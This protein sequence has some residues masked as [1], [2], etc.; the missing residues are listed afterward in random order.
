MPIHVDARN[1][2]PAKELHGAGEG[3]RTL[4]IQ[5]GKLTLYQL[6]YARSGRLG[7]AWGGK[8]TRRE[9]EVK[10]RPDCSEP[11]GRVGFQKGVLET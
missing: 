6:S 9:G 3:T 10:R 11:A 5:L 7:A 4:D 2:A 1:S 8:G